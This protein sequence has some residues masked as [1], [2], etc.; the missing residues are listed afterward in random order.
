MK[1]KLC[2][3]LFCMTLNDSE[4]RTKPLLKD[5]EKYRKLYEQMRTGPI[6]KVHKKKPKKKKKKLKLPHIDFSEETLGG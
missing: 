3:F 2:L 1:L 4:A 5:Q 6:L